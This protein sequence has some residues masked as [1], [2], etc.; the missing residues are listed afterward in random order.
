MSKVALGLLDMLL[1]SAPDAR[2]VRISFVGCL[3]EAFKFSSRP[4]KP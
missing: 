4:T 1:Q 2:C 3:L